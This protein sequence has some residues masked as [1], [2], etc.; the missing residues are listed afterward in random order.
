MKTR[1]FAIG[2]AGISAA[3]VACGGGG[4]NPNPPVR[5]SPTPIVTATPTPYGYG[6][7]MSFAGTQQATATF[8]YPSPSPYPSTSTALTIT[9]TVSVGSSPNPPAPASAGDFHTVE[10]DA[11]AL[12]T[13]TTTTDAWL[14]LSGAELVE[15]LSKS[16]DDSGNSL[17]AT[18]QPALV[19]DEYPETGGASWSNG[20]GVS[21][22][23]KD[24][25]GSS[26]TRVY[27]GNGTYTET[28]NSVANN[29]KTTITENADGSGSISTNGTYLGGAVN[30]IQIAAPSNNQITVTVNYVQPP[31][32]S[33]APSGQP[34]PTP[35][36]TIAPVV[37]TA[38]AWYG[39][40]APVFYSQN[41]VVTTGVSYPSSCSVP[42]AYGT[43]GNELVQT[44]NSL[45]TVMGYTETHVQTTYTNS[46]YGPVCVVI[47]DVQNDY[48]DYQDDFGVANGYHLHFPGT[49]LSTSTLSQT[50]TLQAGAT[51]HD[52]VRRA[53]S[54]QTQT[55]PITMARIAAA[56]AAVRLQ[57]ERAR[58]A[59]EM[60]FLRS[61]A[62]HGPKEIR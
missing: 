2:L 44:T 4:G 54:Q 16:V 21:Y 15:Y 22:A 18:Y 23:E 45:D 52:V 27:A 50:L 19:L 20:A 26:S 41:T 33:P 13:H 57:A 55:V 46:Q 58:H 30:D 34:S 28:T 5:S 25:D 47:S 48:Y 9:Q 31:T 17:T 1:L 12:V 24:A 42:A 36:P 40:S 32:P 35:A 38:P 3:L 6:D 8:A 62:F 60:H 59:R 49:A 37:Y 29:V 39:T 10:T 14:G 7:S 61:F 51:V 56:N 53:Q 43:S 11:S